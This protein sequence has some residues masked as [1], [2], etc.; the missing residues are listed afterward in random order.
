[1]TITSA[2]SAYFGLTTHLEGGPTG[3]LMS[4]VVVCV[5]H[6]GE[7]VMEEKRAGLCAH[8]S[9]TPFHHKSGGPQTVDWTTTR[10]MIKEVNHAGLDLKIGRF[11]GRKHA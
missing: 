10:S 7:V 8:P 9:H 3:G 5:G 6:Q 11:R 1:M 2:F 4:Q